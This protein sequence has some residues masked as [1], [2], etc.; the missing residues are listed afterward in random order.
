MG[1]IKPYSQISVPCDCRIGRI[2]DS[3]KEGLG[4]KM[5]LAMKERVAHMK[6]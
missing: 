1:F 5:K 3:M 4:A 2:K 6:E